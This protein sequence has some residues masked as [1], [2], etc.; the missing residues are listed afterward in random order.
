M[1]DIIDKNWNSLKLKAS[2]LIRDM[3]REWKNKPQSGRKYL[4]NTS[5]IKD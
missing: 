1:K 5:L 2:D 3:I 4:Q